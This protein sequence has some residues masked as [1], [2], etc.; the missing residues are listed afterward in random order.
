MIGVVLGLGTSV[1]HG[2]SFAHSPQHK[3]KVLATCSG[4]QGPS[5]AP[6]TFQH[7]FGP[8]KVSFCNKKTQELFVTSLQTQVDHLMMR[9]PNFDLVTQPRSLN[10]PDTMGTPWESRLGPKLDFGDLQLNLRFCQKWGAVEGVQL[11]T[12]M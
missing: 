3:V 12:L 9:L 8:G 11:F 7:C 10:A 1:S 2:T 5:G 4:A 6:I